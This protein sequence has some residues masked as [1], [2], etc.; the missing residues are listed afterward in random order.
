MNKI[1]GYRNMLGKTQKEMAQI[2]G[3][4]TN[5]YNKKEQGQTPFKDDEKILFKDMLSQYFPS[6]TIDDIFFADR[7]KKS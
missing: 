4:S 3:I 1:R 2:F 5:A 6:I 7:V